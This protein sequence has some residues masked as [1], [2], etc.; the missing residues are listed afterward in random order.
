MPR[1]AFRPI[2]SRRKHVNWTSIADEMLDTAEEKSKP[3]LIELHEARVEDWDANITF[4]ARKTLDRE[5]LKVHV[6]PTGPDAER[7]V[8]VTEGTPER[9]IE[10]R[11]PGGVLVFPSLYVPKTTPGGGY[12]GPGSSGGDLI[13]TTIVRDHSIAARHFEKHI[14]KEYQPTFS[15]DMENA[16][17]RG[18]RKTKVG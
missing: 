15:R 3:D 12:G 2:R 16:S 18:A 7:W 6:W 17:R 9:D 4:K 8:W 14:K 1:V 11:E 10:P 13:F 5:G